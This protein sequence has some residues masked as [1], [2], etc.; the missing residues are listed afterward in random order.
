MKRK[1]VSLLVLVGVIVALAAVTVI[2]AG[3]IR[4]NNGTVY[5]TP[6]P[7][8]GEVPDPIAIENGNPVS[9]VRYMSEKIG[10]KAVS[11]ADI[12]VRFKTYDESGPFLKQSIV[13]IRHLRSGQIRVQRQVR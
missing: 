3:K 7:I 1:L 5:F 2:A 4:E 10:D 9:F 6:D 11:A 13:R 8:T 12:I